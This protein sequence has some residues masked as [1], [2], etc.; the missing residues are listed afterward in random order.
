M[1]VLLVNGSPHADGCVFTSLSEIAETLKAE[2]I[3]SEIFWI[4][5]KAVQGCIACFQCRSELGHCVFQDDLYKQFTAK[6]QEADA[7]IIGAPVYY[8]GPPGSLCAILDRIC[9]S[10]A[11]LFKHKPAACIV[12]C[13]RGGA[14]STFDRLNKYFTILEMPVISSQYWNSTHGTTPDEVRQDLE[15]LQTM[16]TLARNMAYHLKSQ[17]KAALPLPEQEERVGT[18]FIR[19]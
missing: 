19:K 18:N 1:K 6:M 17:K 15:G 7:V 8:A 2:N 5:T 10:A 12:N 11:E 14:S 16:R 13:R 3:E 4:G 9:F